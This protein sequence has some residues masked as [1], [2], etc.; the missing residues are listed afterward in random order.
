MCQLLTINNL[1]QYHNESPVIVI[2][3][4]NNITINRIYTLFYTV[5]EQYCLYK[6]YK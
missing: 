3:I 2:I 6:L 5:Y 4:N 1:T